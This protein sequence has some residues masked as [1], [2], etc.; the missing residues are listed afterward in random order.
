[1]KRLSFWIST[2][3]IVLTVSCQGGNGKEI[4][5]N[6]TTSASTHFQHVTTDSI[7]TIA[8]GK[9]TRKERRQMKKAQ[10]QQDKQLKEAPV[11]NAPNQAEIDSIKN[12]KAK[13]KNQ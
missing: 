2:Y 11:H 4:K 1:M 5:E 9:M 8:K 12:A 3:A 13:L 10:R 7:N 6:N